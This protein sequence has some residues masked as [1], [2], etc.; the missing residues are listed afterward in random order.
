VP[1]SIRFCDISEFQPNVDQ[2]AY[3][4]AGHRVFIYRGHNGY[5][6]DKCMPARREATRKVP[7]TAVGVYQ[8]VVKDR[9]PVQQ[10]KDFITTMG[11][12]APNEFLI[13]D[14]EEIAPGSQMARAQAWLK[15]VDNWAGFMASL[16]SGDYFFRA[17]LGG[18]SSWGNRPTWV[19]AYNTPEPSQPHTWWQNTDKAAFTG[20]GRAVDGNIFHGTPTDF[21]HRVLGGRTSKP[22]APVPESKQGVATVVKPNGAIETFVENDKG[23]VLHRWQKSENSGDWGDKW[24]SLGTPGKS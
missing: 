22:V 17:Y 21:A 7:F 1:T 24:T 9:D 15:E 18:T 6:P 8:Y 19:A 4:D 20:I 13:C 5:R 23:E 11:R 12:L 14:Y 3:Y 16:Y 10:A 2:Q